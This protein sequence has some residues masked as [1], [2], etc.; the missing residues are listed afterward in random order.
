[1]S[2]ACDISRIPVRESLS[3]VSVASVL[4]CRVAIGSK[5]LDG[6]FPDDP[7]GSSFHMESV[8]VYIGVG[9]SWSGEVV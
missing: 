4:N 1:M 5:L 2:A 3:S 9:I 6:P 7:L 8:S